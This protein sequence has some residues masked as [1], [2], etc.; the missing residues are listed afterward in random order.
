MDKQINDLSLMSVEA[1]KNLVTSYSSLINDSLVHQDDVLD[2]ARQKLRIEVHTMKIDQNARELL[3]CIRRIKELKVTDDKYQEE[4]IKF[5]EECKESS[6]QIDEQVKICYKQLT[7]LSTE[8]FEV[9]QA[10][11]KLLR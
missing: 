10:A 3:T 1:I 6:K 8:G 5:E 11:S 9:L 4:R 2:S 7:D